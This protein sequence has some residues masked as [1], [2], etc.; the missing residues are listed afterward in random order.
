MPIETYCAFLVASIVILIIPGPTIM[1]VVSC[2]LAQGK[3]AALPLA[4]GVGLG[5]MVALIAS[6]VGLGALLATSAAM[7]T[8]LKWIGAIYLMYLGIKMTVAIFAIFVNPTCALAERCS[9]YFLA[10]H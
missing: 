9:V 7:F 5:D 2:S 6:M 3:R 10:T 1:L 8:I 4:L